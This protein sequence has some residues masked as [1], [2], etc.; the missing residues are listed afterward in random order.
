[1]YFLTSK[2]YTIQSPYTGSSGGWSACYYNATAQGDSY[3]IQCTNRQ[4]PFTRLFGVRA[5]VIAI[6]LREVEIYGY[7]SYHLLLLTV[8]FLTFISIV[9][10]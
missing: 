6:E 7:G 3:T 9:H 4:T 2:D 5:R 8:Y 10:S 1:M